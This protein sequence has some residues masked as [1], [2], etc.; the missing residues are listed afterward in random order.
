MGLDTFAMQ[1]NPEFYTK[2]ESEWA[3]VPEEQRPTQYVCL[4]A[5]HFK[6]VP[7]VL[8]GGMFSG[9]GPGPSFRGKVYDEVVTYITGQTLY[10]EMISNEV[11][12]EM[13]LK[14]GVA[15]HLDLADS[16][17]KKF[18]LTRQELRA[19]AQW[20]RVAADA[21]AMVHGWW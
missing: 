1:E 20:F 21:G 15:A 9:N 4:D 6:D 8:C 16:F 10:E 19:L 18:D 13:A 7:N 14:L 2:S 11:V 17:Y 5:E 12:E 3:A